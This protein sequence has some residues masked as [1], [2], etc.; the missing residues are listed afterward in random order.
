MRRLCLVATAIIGA[1]LLIAWVISQQVL[2]PKR[3]VEDHGLDD[4]GLRAEGVS[5]PSR[6][7]TRLAGWF[8]PAANTP[9]PAIVLSHGWARSRAE[10]LPHADLLHRAG[11]AV[12]LFDYRHRGESE[13]DAVT[14]GLGE[15]RDLLGALD[16]IAARPEVDADRIAVLGMSLGSVV[17]ILTA[18]GDRRVR[19]LVAECPYATSG[20]IMTRALRHYFHLPRFPVAPLAK[21]LIERRLGESLAGADPAQAMARISPRPVFIIADERDAIFGA[22]ETERVFQAMAEPKQFWLVP[23]AD[24]ARGWQAA[25]AEYERRVVDFLRGALAVD[26]PLAAARG[27]T[28]P[29][30]GGAAG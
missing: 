2:H 3:R 18:A 11:F 23:G 7:G 14:M 4:F 16:A 17:A 29:R 15:H 24:H 13:G 1:S 6:D 28:Q 21:W 12:L 10:L 30:H 25:P 20:A 22:D 26:S 27:S 9:S 8:I 5:F 19:A